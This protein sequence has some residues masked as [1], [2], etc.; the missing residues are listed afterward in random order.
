MRHLHCPA[1]EG[2][3]FIHE[4]NIKKDFQHKQISFLGNRCT[5]PI[6]QKEVLLPISES[7]NNNTTNKILTYVSQHYH[8]HTRPVQQEL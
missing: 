5:V 3:T 1:I 6:I 2:T 7:Y 8:P 4:K